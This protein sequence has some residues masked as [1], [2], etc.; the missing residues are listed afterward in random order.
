MDKPPTY[1]TEGITLGKIA[2]HG[3]IA[4]MGGIVHELVHGT[5]YSFVRFLAGSS[6]GAFTGM[7]TYA[8]CKHFEM[9][10]W[11]TIAA[12]GMAGFTGAPLLDIGSRVLKTFVE[13]NIPK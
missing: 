9:G 12:V 8:V 1:I 2:I 11:I 4:V 13:R 3:I 5:G 10:E 7:M 6:I